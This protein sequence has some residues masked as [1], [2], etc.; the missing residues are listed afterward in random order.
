MKRSYYVHYY[1]DFGNTYNLY[2]ADCPEMIANLPD[3]AE[4]I[5]YKRAVELCRREREA[6]GFDQ[7]FSGYADAMIMPAIKPD[8]SPRLGYGKPDHYIVPLRDERGNDLRA[9]VT[10]EDKQAVKRIGCR[11]VQW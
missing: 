5:T 9:L 1:R 7:A 6:R 3:G 2:W 8:Y 10:C 11:D 4:R